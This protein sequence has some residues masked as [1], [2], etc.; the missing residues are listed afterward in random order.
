MPSTLCQLCQTIPLN[1]L[2]RFPDDSYGRGLSG[3]PKLHTMWHFDT[4]EE[5]CDPLG[6]HYHDGLE[7]LRSASASGC[8]LCRLVEI[9]ADALLVDIAERNLKYAKYPEEIKQRHPLDPSF[10]LW[11]TQRPEGGDGFWVIAKSMSEPKKRLFLVAT[12]GFGS[13]NGAATVSAQPS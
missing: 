11:I 9:E 13:E 7:S 12:F 8:E 2:P 6:F 4:M 3:M 5:P 10:D 1:D